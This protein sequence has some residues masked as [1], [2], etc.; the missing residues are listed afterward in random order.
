M[1]WVAFC[2][3]GESSTPALA[4]M[5]TLPSAPNVARRCR[6]HVCP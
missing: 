4:M 3:D 1:K 2:A 6:T 5:P